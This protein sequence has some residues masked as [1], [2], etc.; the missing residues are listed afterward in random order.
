M[1]DLVWFG[2]NMAGFGLVWLNIEKNTLQSSLLAI[3]HIFFDQKHELLGKHIVSNMSN[4]ETFR[5]E[6]KIIFPTLVVVLMSYVT[7]LNLHN[8]CEVAASKY[9]Q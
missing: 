9:S 2:K 8:I 7:T 4:L 1:N 5:I 6:D 3:L